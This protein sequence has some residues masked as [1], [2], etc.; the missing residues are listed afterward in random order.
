MFYSLLQVGEE[1]YIVLG[2]IAAS[3]ERQE[4][5]FYLV[6]IDTEFS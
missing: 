1:E 2:E 6:K 3:Y 5:D 4:Q